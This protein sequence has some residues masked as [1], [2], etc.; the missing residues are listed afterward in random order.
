MKSLYFALA[1]FLFHLF[2]TT[3]HAQVRNGGEL[4]GYIKD[5]FGNAISSATVRIAGTNVV[6]SAD[7]DGFYKLQ[8][9][10]A[11]HEADIVITAIGFLTERKTTVVKDGKHTIDFILRGDR[12]QIDEVAVTGQTDNERH[13][14]EIARSGFNVSVIDLNKFSNEA[15][16]LTQVLKRATGVTIRE[17]GGL[18]SNFVFRINGLDAKIFIDGVP[19]DNFGTS[20]TLNNIPVN[21]VDR[22]EIYKGVVPAFLGSDALGGAVNIITKRRAR[23]FLDLS[24]STG[25]FNTHQA[26]LVGTF[27]NP[28]NKLSVRLNG[29]Y[30]HSDND[31]TMY[32]EEKYN[33]IL[34]GERNNKLD[35]IDQVKRF[36]DAYTSAMGQLEVGFRDKSWAD[37]FYVGLTYSQN[38]KQNQ[39]GAT[40]NT[41]NVGQW[42][43][44]SYWMPTLSYKK[45]DFVV[46]RLYVDLF[47]SYS[48]DTRN[49]R[50]TAAYNYSWSGNW[51]P[52]GN[53]PPRDPSHT[54]Y[55]LSNYLAR[56]NL[57]YDFDEER[58]Q[59]INLNY[60]YNSSSQREFD[61]INGYDRS[62]LPSSLGRHILG[63]SWQNQWLDKRL[64]NVLALKY[65]RLD[66]AKDID[67]REYNGNNELVEGELIHYEKAWNFYSMSLASR[68]R[69]TR[70]GGWKLSYERAYNLPVMTQFFGDG[71][72][73]ISNFDLKPERSDNINTGFYY[74][75]FLNEENFLN[76]DVTGFYRLAADYINTRVVDIN[77]DGYSQFYNI[78][79]VKLY[80]LAAELKYGYK[81]LIAVTLNGSYDKAIDNKKYTDD[82]NQ[83]VSLSYGY[84]IPNRP[85]VYGS[86]DLSLIQNDWFQ[87]GS[88]VQLS[89]L[90]QYN[91]WFYLSESHLGSLSSKDHIPSQTIHSAILSYSWSN[92][93][94]N[95]SAEA[96]NLTDER[97]YDNFRLQK[98]GRAY[99]L[100]F[101]V[102][103]M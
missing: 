52:I 24:Y 37:Q 4:S 30:N 41:L 62:G 93:R 3:A 49:V 88:R 57:N 98:P 103:L 90:T 12:K 87:K 76:V 96:R 77:G 69:I 94:Y 26:A 16:N 56:I 64:S 82:S 42:S 7:Y 6:T 65:Y 92:N 20:M 67:E 70:D 22:V 33:V 91:H 85:W 68:Y 9:N 73:T 51:V 102:S 79:G 35:T 66:A 18:G 29:F 17:D 28:K 45:S 58:K 60:N 44:S 95:I 31:Y 39:L 74:N 80:G 78:P 97:A 8:H 83:E 1:I 40:I 38:H 63:L 99:Y 53:E 2:G 15:A 21:L 89:Y 32:S 75:S 81:D 55:E 25:S 72:N 27:T 48:M 47:S 19:M 34:R 100:K 23:P 46:K 61:M 71:L 43:E 10:V 14:R 86:M 11:G 84:Q 101:R 54:K 50:D 36:Y 13:V 5:T 59:S